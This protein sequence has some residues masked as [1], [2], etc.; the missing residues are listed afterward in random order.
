MDSTSLANSA[1]YRDALLDIFTVDWLNP[2][3][4]QGSGYHFSW[5]ISGGATIH[6]IDN[7]YVANYIRYGYPG[8]VAYGLL[9]LQAVGRWCDAGFKRRTEQCY[10]WRLRSAGTS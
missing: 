3:L 7:F 9:I 10:V 5:Y 8:L 4:G 6:S 2:W 1:S